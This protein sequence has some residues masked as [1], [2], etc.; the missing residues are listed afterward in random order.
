MHRRVQRP[1][2]IECAW[3]AAARFFRFIHSD[4]YETWGV[5]RRAPRIPVAAPGSVEATATWLAGEVRAGDAVLV[6]GG[7]RSYRIGE[8][9]LEELARR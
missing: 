4:R 2:G 5:A 3:P 9:L 8:V 1:V 7:G 6:M